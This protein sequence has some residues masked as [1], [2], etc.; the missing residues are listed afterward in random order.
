MKPAFAMVRILGVGA[1]F[2]GS[3]CAAATMDFE[4]LAVGT[5]FGQS[6]G[7]LPGDTV[8][9]QDGIDMSVETFFFTGQPNDFFR[10][11]IVGSNEFFSTKHVE[12]V[13]IN[14]GFDLTQL[15]FDVNLV[16]VEYVELGGLNNFSVNG[17]PI[18][19][20]TPLSDLQA[21]I[22]PGVTLALEVLDVNT[23]RTRITLTGNVDNFLIGGQEL[24]VDTI[25]AVPEPA[26]LVL[27]ACGVFAVWRG[28][29]KLGR[30]A[31]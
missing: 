28:C 10:A 13:G 30:V 23:G 26:T 27:L 12:T 7:D 8:F 18:I 17:E 16:S 11:E 5:S 20:I 24:A 3:I 31:V 4:P 29:R 14:L 19:Q 6:A 1:C 22:A 9:T 15:G 21:A 2:G 25:V